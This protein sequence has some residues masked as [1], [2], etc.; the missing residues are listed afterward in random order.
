MKLVIRIDGTWKE[1][2]VDSLAAAKAAADK[3]LPDMNGV[4]VLIVADA[5]AP[6]PVEP[7]T[8]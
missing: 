3:A 6:A 2:T 7:K 8:E 5:P 4:V 1:T